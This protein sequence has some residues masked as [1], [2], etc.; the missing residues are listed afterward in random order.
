M[1][2]IY[3]QISL[4]FIVLIGFNA[5]AQDINWISWEEAVQLSKSDAQPK[6]IC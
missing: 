4:L 3:T 1:R 6:N 5:Q 2:T